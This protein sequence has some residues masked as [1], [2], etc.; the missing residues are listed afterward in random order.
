MA[1]DSEDKRPKLIQRKPVSAE[2]RRLLQQNF[3]RGEQAKNRDRGYA[4]EMYAQCVIGDPGNR[5]YVMAF[6]DNLQKKFNNKGKGGRLSSFSGMG[7]R[8]TLKKSVSKGE[9]DKAIR[10]GVDLLRLNPWDIPA[11]MLLSE[12]AAG[13]GCY[14]TQLIFLNHATKSAPDPGDPEIARSCAKALAAL[15]QFDQAIG[16]WE[17]VKKYHQNND[18]AQHAIA[19]LH[20]DKIGWVGS[21]SRDEA[22]NAANKAGGKDTRETELNAR[23][24]ADPASIDAASDLADFLA[25]EDRYEDA[26]TVLKT[27]FS[28]TGDAKVQEHL[29]DIRLRRYRHQLA[30]AEKRAHD[31]PS[32]A[33]KKLLRNMQIELLRIELEIFRNRSERY[34]GNTNIKFEYAIRLKRAG[35]YN[36]AIKMLQD[37]R[38]DPK[39]KPIVFYELGNCFFKIKQFKLAMKNYADSLEMMTDRDL[40]LRKRALY[41][42]GVVAMDY[43]NDLDA[44]ERHLTTLA[45]LD[46]SYEDVSQRLD[47][48]NVERHKQ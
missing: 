38:N 4:D 33:T 8:A 13:L 2:Q 39:K 5:V 46:F 48:I 25:H 14:E 44:A 30:I 29:E 15:G 19:G 6:L 36:E 47:K 11:L 26:E 3:E 43:L 35:N 9:L 12:A 31:D 23:F 32:D 7:A 10:A 37:A 40:D 41:R 21:A 1:D 45:G 16:C 24:D 20:T 17:R 34:P 22:K 27:S 28:A 42:A 18:E